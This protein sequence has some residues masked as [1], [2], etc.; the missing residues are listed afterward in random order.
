MII[1]TIE[2]A[3]MLDKILTIVSLDEIFFA[4]LHMYDP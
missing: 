4:I 3:Y 1:G 2:F